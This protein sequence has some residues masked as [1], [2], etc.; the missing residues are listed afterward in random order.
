MK[1]ILRKLLI[2]PLSFAFIAP[3]FAQDGLGETLKD[4]AEQ[5]GKGY[6]GPVVTAFGTGMNSGTFHRAKPHKILGFDVT[7]NITGIS[8]PEA[9]QEFEFTIPDNE[10]T[11]PPI[12]VGTASYQIPIPFSTL[13]SSGQ[14]VPTFFGDKDGGEIPVNSTAARAE[15]MSYLVDETGQSEADLELAAG[16]AIDAAVGALEPLPTPGGIGLPVFATMMP[17]FSVGLPLNIELTFRGFTTKVD[18]DELKFGG[19]GAK[20]G[21]SEFIPLFPVD[22]A[23][24]FYSTNLNFAEI[25]KAQNSILTLQAS[26]S[27]PFI[28]VYGGLGIESSS[29]SVEYEFQPEGLAAV[30]IEFDMDGDNKTRFTAGLRLKLAL[31]SLQADINTG[32]FTAFNLGLGLTFR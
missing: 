15:I 8:I 1:N 25:V 24:G 26:K 14:M 12:A 18:D 7:I 11:T 19:F 30:P 17:Q 23:A 5:N 21:F 13:Y 32:E 16:T 2:I 27:I 6:L 10:V 4:L 22:L 20:I 28:T 3:A 29:M 9:G 31:L